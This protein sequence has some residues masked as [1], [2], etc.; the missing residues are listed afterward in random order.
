[1]PRILLVASVFV[2]VDGF[3]AYQHSMKRANEIDLMPDSN[4]TKA[5]GF[6]SV[7]APAI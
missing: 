7:R 4:G 1:M 3:A 6:S 2:N 5:A